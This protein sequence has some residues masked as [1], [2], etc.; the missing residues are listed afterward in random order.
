MISIHTDEKG[1]W[2]NKMYIIDI[3]RGNADNEIISVAKNRIC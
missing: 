1:I 2:R 3:L